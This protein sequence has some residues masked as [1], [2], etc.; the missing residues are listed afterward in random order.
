MAMEPSMPG[1]W[2]AYKDISPSLSPINENKTL[3]VT[4]LT[5]VVL[6]GEE[7]VEGLESVQDVFDHFKPE[8]GA[9]LYD[10]AGM[11]SYENF[12]YRRLG[13]FT[14]QGLIDQSPLLRELQSRKNDL[15][16]INMHLR[17]N[18]LLQAAVQ[19]PQAKLVVL[20]MIQQMLDE[21]EAA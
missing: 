5:D 9:T 4:K 3:Y 20:D 1:A 2:A 13:D 16:K 10:Q 12:Q 21:I 11:P 15:Q 6:P 7:K 8:S 14:Q 18:K 19:N 17:S